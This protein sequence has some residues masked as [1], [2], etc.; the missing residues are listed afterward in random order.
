LLWVVFG[1]RIRELDKLTVADS[2]YLMHSI[3]IASRCLIIAS[4]IVVVS[5]II[6]FFYDEAVGQA[7]SVLGAGVYFGAPEVFGRVIG[8]LNGPAVGVVAGI[9]QQFALVGVICLA[10]GLVLVVRDCILRIWRG[11][12]VRRVLEARWGDEKR[13]KSKKPKFYGSCWDMSFCR[14]FVRRVC[15]AFQAKKPC[16][17]VKVGCYCD[18]HTILMAMAGEGDGN[19]SYKGILHSLGLDGQS[20]KPQ[21]SAKVKRARCRRCGIYS[22]HQRQKYRVFSPMVFPSVTLALYLFYGQIS[23]YVVQA[24]EKTD[25]FVSFL[26]YKAV[27]SFSIATDQRM[28]VNLAVVWLGIIIV[29]YTLRTLEYLIF[30]VQV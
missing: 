20:K 4:A 29:S 17:R 22:E 6:R 30:D 9:V 23:A 24:L 21:V 10:P 28:I 15:P 26:T 12:S 1:E 5:L 3:A 8:S 7:L 16:W 14:E 19:E 2:T 13:L 25:K 27:D 11:V 18:E